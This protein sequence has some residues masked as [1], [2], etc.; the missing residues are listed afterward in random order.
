MADEI[1][2]V[3]NT[4]ALAKATLAPAQAPVA[5]GFAD[6]VPSNWG[7]TSEGDTIIGTNLVT[8]RQF[9]GTMAEFNALLR[10]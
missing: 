3:A 7:L 1:K 2:V 9:S 6:K 8:G 10:S 5:Y 4:A